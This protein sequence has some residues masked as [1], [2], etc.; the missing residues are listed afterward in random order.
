MDLLCDREAACLS[1]G[2]RQARGRGGLP[3]VS[4]LRRM[5]AGGMLFGSGGLMNLGNSITTNVNQFNIAINIIFNG[6]SI[7]NNQL[8]GLGLSVSA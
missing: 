6:G 2:H 1:G 7:V 8:N 3:M 5:A 4:L